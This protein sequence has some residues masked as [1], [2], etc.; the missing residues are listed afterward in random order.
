MTSTLPKKGEFFELRPDARRRGKG[1]GVVFENESFLK[2]P[3]NFL[4]RPDQG[5][6]PPLRETPRLVYY[7]SQG[8]PPEDLEAGMSGYW[9]VSGRLREV[10]EA[11]DPG[12]FAFRETDYR[13]ADGAKG[14][15]YFLCDVVRTIDALD[16]EASQL[17]VIVSDDYEEGKYYGLTGDVRLAFKP[18]IVGDAHVFR[19]PYYEGVFCDRIFKEAVEAAGL[20]ANGSSSG[21]WFYD[22]VN[23]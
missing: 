20:V 19:L 17:K 18:D 21:L 12:A 7:P 14:G 2:T 10:M 22:A 5:G 9:L 8:W 11:V 6:F 3:P 16:E 15:P 13:L 1:H 4:L 23:C